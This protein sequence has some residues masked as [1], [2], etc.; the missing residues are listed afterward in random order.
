V[1]HRRKLTPSPQPLLPSAL[2]PYVLAA[3]VRAAELDHLEVWGATDKLLTLRL[4]PSGY[5]R[6]VPM[7]PELSDLVPPGHTAPGPRW[8]P[9]W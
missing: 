5:F 2:R 7:T 3:G 1:D 9:R 8:A 6:Y 4:R